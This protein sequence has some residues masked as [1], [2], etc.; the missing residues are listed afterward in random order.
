MTKE[1][2]NFR[3]EEWFKEDLKKYMAIHNL[4][5]KTKALHRYTKELKDQSNQRKNQQIEINSQKTE[6][7]AWQ[8]IQ[9]RCDFL[10]KTPQNQYDCLN[11]KPPIRVTHPLFSSEICGICQKVSEQMKQISKMVESKALGGISAHCL[12]TNE[13]RQKYPQYIP[14]KQKTVASQV[15]NEL[16]KCPRMKNPSFCSFE[17]CDRRPQ[18][19]EERIIQ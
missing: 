15:S 11:K 10:I 9:L 12:I 5:N 8:D 18:C 6:S 16:F 2:F 4:D 19:R 3:M 1:P 17:P 7:S 13:T 14:D